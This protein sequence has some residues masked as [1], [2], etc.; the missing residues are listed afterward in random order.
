MQ[1]SVAH[2]NSEEP[3]VGEGMPQYGVPRR[4]WS[5]GVIKTP[6]CETRAAERRMRVVR[7]ARTPS[8]T[9]RRRNASWP[10]RI[11]AGA[12]PIPHVRPDVTAPDND[13]AESRAANFSCLHDAALGCRTEAVCVGLSGRADSLARLD[14][15]V[16]NNSAPNLRLNQTAEAQLQSVGPT[17]KMQPD[18]AK[19]FGSAC[20]PVFRN[21]N[22]PLIES[23]ADIRQTGPWGP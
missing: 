13:M 19:A 9:K 7:S 10:E 3:D 23:G 1:V 22:L 2:R 20:L 18:P 12:N 11:T 15:L 21:R 17:V 6:T 16:A 4:Y 5:P 14:L 8:E